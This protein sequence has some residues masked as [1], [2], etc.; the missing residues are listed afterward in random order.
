MNNDKARQRMLKL[1][2]LAR[3]GEGGES[4]N[5]QRFLESMLKRHGMT[6]ADLGEDDQATEWMKFPFRTVQDRRLLAQVASMVLRTNS[7]PS[8]EYRGE[9]ALWLQI[10]KAQFL[11]IELH[12]RAF[13]RDLKKALELAFIAFINRNDIFSGVASD[14]SSPPQHSMEDMAVVAAMMAGMP[15]TAVHREL[16]H[17]KGARA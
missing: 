5:A 15:R 10:T 11:E 12:F 1:L 4:D 9:K 14:D 2:A 13:N 8:R 17:E 7:L 3:R 16:T 6:L